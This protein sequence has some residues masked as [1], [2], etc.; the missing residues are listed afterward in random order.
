MYLTLS[1]KGLGFDTFQTNLLVIPSQVG[2]II[3]MMIMTYCAEIYGELSLTA[4]VGQIW[5]LPFLI[6]IYVVD[7]NSINKWLAWGIMT[8]LLAY[9][10]GTPPRYVQ[11]GSCQ[12]PY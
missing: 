8:T 3:L 11:V 7:I 12:R 5:T 6:Y 2:H 1:L 4:M 9:P 10:S